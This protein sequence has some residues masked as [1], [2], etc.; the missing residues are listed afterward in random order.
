MTDEEILA[1][2]E[3]QEKRFAN[4]VGTDPH[5]GRIKLRFWFC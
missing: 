2:I 5:C 3:R 1:E 4:E